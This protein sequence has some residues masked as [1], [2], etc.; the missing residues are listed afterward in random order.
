MGGL[1]LAHPESGEEI[2]TIYRDGEV[3]FCLADVITILAKQNTQLATKSKVDGLSGLMKAQLEAL[4]KDEL[5]YPPAGSIEDR[6]KLHYVTQ[7]GLFRIILRDSSAASKKFQRWVLHEV[8][9]SIQKYGTYPPPISGD[10]S[11]LMKTAQLLVCEIQE[12]ERLERETKERF[13]K[14]ERLLSALSDRLAT[15]EQVPMYDIAYLSVKDYCLQ[16][17]IDP[18]HE[19]LIFGWCIK[20]CAE[21]GGNTKKIIHEGREVT[22]FPD[23]VVINAWKEALQT[24]PVSQNGQVPFREA[25]SDYPKLSGVN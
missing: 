9:P 10:T 16:Q 11:A 8:L 18:V 17:N 23:H 14:H 2:K 12:R 3:L 20:I 21:K 13:D 25:T 7:P 6:D 19:H 4:E 24:I 5:Y 1:V 15:Q 22:L